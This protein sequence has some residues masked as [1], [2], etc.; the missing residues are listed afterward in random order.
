[1]FII[2][3]AKGGDVTKDELVQKERFQKYEF[4]LNT[5]DLLTNSTTTSVVQ[6][7]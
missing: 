5:D 7:I 1:L 3:S 4:F 6:P 2:N